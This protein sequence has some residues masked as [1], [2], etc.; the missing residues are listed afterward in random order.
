M[1]FQLALHLLGDRDE[2][3]DLSQEVFLRVFR[4]LSSFRGQSALR[5]WIYRIV[6]NQARN[7]QRWWRRRHQSAQVPLEVHAIGEHLHGVVEA[8]AF[9]RRGSLRELAR[10]GLQRGGRGLLVARGDGLARRARE[11]TEA[12]GDLLP[13][14]KVAYVHRLVKSGEKVLMVGDDISTD[15]LG[16]SAAGLRTHTTPLPEVASPE[17]GAGSG[18]EAGGRGIR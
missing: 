3:L 18:V 8:C 1:V 12:H 9:R 15:I 11:I 5:T 4:T 14:A 2:A 17:F 13:E 7:R 6:I 10:S 16:A